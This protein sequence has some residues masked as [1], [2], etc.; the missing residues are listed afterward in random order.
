[1]YAS[2]TAAVPLAQTHVFMVQ[3]S[4]LGGVHYTQGLHMLYSHSVQ[5]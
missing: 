5:C 1:M 2:P 3:K 4:S